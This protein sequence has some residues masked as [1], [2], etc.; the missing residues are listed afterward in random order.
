LF[1]CCETGR[2]RFLF[3][4][5]LADNERD[6]GIDRFCGVIDGGTIFER[7]DVDLEV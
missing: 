2:F 5:A 6:G 3:V 1:D 4:F 7:N